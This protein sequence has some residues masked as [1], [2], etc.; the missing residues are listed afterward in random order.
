[1]N[2]NKILYIDDQ[3]ENGL[4]AMEADPRIDFLSDIPT[5]GFNFRV[6][7]LIITDMQMKHAESGLQVIREAISQGKLPWVATGGTYEHGGLFNRVSAFNHLDIKNFDRTSKKEETFWRAFISFIEHS[8]D[9]VK[10]IALEE[11]YSLEGLVPRDSASLIY[12][13]YISNYNQLKTR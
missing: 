6:Y 4:A 8:G 2:I 7:D 5:T 1:M 13:F 10:S 11:V 12:D 9:K 3:I